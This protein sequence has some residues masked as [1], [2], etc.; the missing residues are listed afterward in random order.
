[1]KALQLLVAFA[2]VTAV[3]LVGCASPVSDEEVA[4]SG[5]AQSIGENAGPVSEL[6][7]EW[8]G[9]MSSV[10]T[11][12]NRAVRLVL[13][14]DGTFEVSIERNKMDPLFQ[15]GHWIEEDETLYF[16][17]LHERFAC[18]VVRNKQAAMRVEPPVP[19]GELARFVSG[20]DLVIDCDDRPDLVLRRPPP[21]P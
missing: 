18:R 3:S 16:R 7:G 5:D 10:D 14:N 21:S 13:E 9:S 11:Y 15:R 12:E 20:S 8:V 19:A 1:M 6:G 2:S 17:N 4:Q